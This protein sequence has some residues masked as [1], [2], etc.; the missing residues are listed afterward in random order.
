MVSETVS[1]CLNL[2]RPRVSSA[3]T[4]GISQAVVNDWSYN[5]QGATYVRHEEIFAGNG[6]GGHVPALLCKSFALG[7][8][9]LYTDFL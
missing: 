8:L 4:T 7:L 5:S 6:F 3:D 9:P 1:T 2:L